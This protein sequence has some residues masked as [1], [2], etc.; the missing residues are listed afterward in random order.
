ME[1]KSVVKA[2]RTMICG[3]NINMSLWAEG[4]KQ[5]YYNSEKSKPPTMN[6]ILKSCQT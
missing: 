6:Y 2:A 1:N 3:K 5:R 4:V